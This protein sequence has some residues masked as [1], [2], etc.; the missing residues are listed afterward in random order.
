MYR[1]IRIAVVS[2]VLTTAC[3]LSSSA[4]LSY[5]TDVDSE[6]NTF[7]VGSISTMLAIYG[8]NDGTIPFAEPDE[9]IVNG[10]IP[11]YLQ[12]E[13]DGNVKVYQRFRVV[14]PSALADV[15]TL[16][17]PC[18]VVNNTCSTTNYIVTY[19]PAVN[20]TDAEYTITSKAVV[21]VGGVTNRWPVRGIVIDGITDVDQSLFTCENGSN[22]CVLGITTYSD[23]IQAAG[24]SDAVSAFAS[25]TGTH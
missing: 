17:L 9:P 10:T 23:A 2:L 16:D 20:E 18:T 11:F 13:N 24:F 5:F 21:A 14:I 3:V 25:L 15:V 8:D 1:K 22:D 19:N 12:A 6:T 7:T 4:T